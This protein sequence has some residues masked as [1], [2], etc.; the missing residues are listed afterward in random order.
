MGFNINNMKY[1]IILFLISCSTIAQTSGYVEYKSK[2]VSQMIDTS[3]IENDDIKK[4]MQQTV[5][6]MKRQ[7][8]YVT[9]E[10]KFADK[11]AVFSMKQQMSVDDAVD[12]KS[13]SNFSDAEGDFFTDIDVELM[14]RK[15]KAWNNEYIIRYSFSEWEIKNERKVILGY[16][17][18]KATTKKQLDNGNSIEVVAWFAKDIPFNFGPK[19]YAGLPGLILEIKER[20]IQFYATQVDLNDKKHN[21]NLPDIDKSITRKEFISQSPYR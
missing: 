8:P 18:I 14:L 13:I 4:S 1:L 19:E 17:C 10:L 5:N 16:D 9:Y 15:L 7:M 6:K 3:N 11:Q 21:I 20:G 12:F 2:I